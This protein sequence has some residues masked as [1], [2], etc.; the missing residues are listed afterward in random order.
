MV[1]VKKL[2]VRFLVLATIAGLIGLSLSGVFSFKS[3]PASGRSGGQVS[4]MP[5]NA[6]L[7]KVEDAPLA[8]RQNLSGVSNNLTASTAKNLAD[9]ILALNPAPGTFNGQTG[10]VVP[11]PA[12]L[13]GYLTMELPQFKVSDLW[14]SPDAEGIVPSSASDAAANQGYVNDFQRVMKG[15]LGDP[16]LLAT[17]QQSSV[18]NS[19]D[20]LMSAIIPALGNAARGLKGIPVPAPFADFHK[21]IL[22]YLEDQ[23]NVLAALAMRKA[24]PFKTIIVLNSGSEID[25]RANQD[26]LAMRTAYQN[27]DLPQ[28]LSRKGSDAGV[29]SRIGTT[30]DSVIGLFKIPTAEADSLLT[31]NIEDV[32]CGS[33]FASSLSGILGSIVQ[34]F[35]L[36]KIPVGDS[37]SQKNNSG[38][39]SALLVRCQGDIITQGA[40][41]GLVD[42]MNNTV[43]SQ[44]QNGNGNGSPSFV[45]NPQNY[46]KAQATPAANQALNQSEFETCSQ[47]KSHIEAA[48]GIDSSNNV[49]LAA[50]D[51]YGDTVVNNDGQ[52][53]PNGDGTITSSFDFGSPQVNGV[54]NGCDIQNTDFSTYITDFG[55]NPDD[56]N[57]FLTAWT[58]PANNVDGATIAAHGAVVSAAGAASAAAGA[59]L[60]ANGGYKNDV[61]CT[62]WVIDATGEAVCDQYQTVTPGSSIASAADTALN[63]QYTAVVNA[64]NPDE[65]DTEVADGLMTQLFANRA[66]G[67]SKLTFKTENALASICQST[68]GIPGIGNNHA[69]NKPIQLC[70]S[71]IG[72]ISSQFNKYANIVQKIGPLI[73]QFF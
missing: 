9:V 27:L 71:T 37:S 73:S 12:I 42:L 30:V 63:S 52:P 11:D 5:Q 34:L 61:E 38:A 45:T 57:T 19:P 24:D 10:F 64:T 54:P 16:A 33:G 67:L 29:L 31:S 47:F 43:I 6:F 15:T 22:V 21:K 46:I 44:V 65:L 20:T 2:A 41:K 48:L 68:F 69:F 53:V 26:L 1:D 62:N 17:I 51:P 32:L 56:W 55:A 3:G 40:K 70:N 35:N 28:L 59:S 23:R 4:L 25:S 72:K 8:L 7:A 13:T 39:L 18:T 50:G 14:V 36:T 66:A 58:N 60:V 49:N